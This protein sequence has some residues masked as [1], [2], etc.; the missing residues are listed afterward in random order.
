MLRIL[1]ML[2]VFVATPLGGYACCDKQAGKQQR[3]CCT[4]EDR[5]ISKR[6][7]PASSCCGKTACHCNYCKEHGHSDAYCQCGCGAGNDLPTP[8]PPTSSSRIEQGKIAAFVSG[9]DCFNG[10]VAEAHGFFAVQSE[11]R[12][13]STPIFLLH[14]SIRT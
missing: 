12:P 4:G 10:P 5:Q 6:A 1:A 2:L 8:L 3:S 13:C 11:G 14:R 7:L 9:A